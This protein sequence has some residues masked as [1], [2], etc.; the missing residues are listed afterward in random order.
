MLASDILEVILGLVL[1]CVGLALVSSMLMES[2]S[3]LLNRRG[4]FLHR[5]IRE[6]LKEDG[7]TKEFYLHPLVSSLYRGGYKEFSTF[8]LPPYIPA[9][10]F[11]LAQGASRLRPCESA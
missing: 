11:A 8:N 9:R 2:A 1:L 3:L 6:L 7:L 5:E 4:A 10:I